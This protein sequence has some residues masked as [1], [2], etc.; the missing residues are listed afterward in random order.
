MGVLVGSQGKLSHEQY[1]GVLANRTAGYERGEPVPFF[2]EWVEPDLTSCTET[3]KKGVPCRAPRV[4]E[5]DV[6]VGHLR[7]QATKEQ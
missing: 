5:H 4:H 1:G 2:G 7:S 3:T 6:C